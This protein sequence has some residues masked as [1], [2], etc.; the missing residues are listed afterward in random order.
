MAA[1][2]YVSFGGDTAALEAATAVVRG[3]MQHLGNEMR[4]LAREFNKAGA[5]A[6]SELGQKLRRLAQDM[7]GAKSVLA[8]LQ[9]QAKKGGDEIHALAEK[10]GN[11][12]WNFSPFS[13]MYV[14]MAQDVGEHLVKAFVSADAAG[15][16][17]G[18]TLGVVAT[19]GAL[20]AAVV[21]GQVSS[22]R[23]LDDAARAAKI[24]M[25]ALRDLNAAGLGVGID[26]GQMNREMAQF[27]QKLREAQI[28]GGDLAD[29]LKANNIA[30]Q[31]AAGHLRPVQ[32]IFGDI[33]NLI[34][35]SN[36]EMD[37]LAALDKLGFSHDMLRLFERQTEAVKTFASSAIAAQD[38]VMRRGMADG[39]ALS[40]AWHG[41]WEDVKGDALSAS[42]SVLST[43]GEIEHRGA[44]EFEELADRAKAAFHSITGDARAAA[45]A[46]AAAFDAQK[47]E[48]LRR[49]DMAV[50]FGKSP[51]GELNASAFPSA[52]K[53]A[54]PSDQPTIKGLYD[55][56]D[57]SSKSNHDATAAAMKASEGEI[58]AAQRT[59]KAKEQLYADGVRLS[60]LSDQQ[61]FAADKAALD[62]EY[63]AERG[64]LQKELAIDG[65]KLAQ[66]QAI[67]DK[68]KALDQRHAEESQRLFMQ[69]VQNEIQEWDRMIDSMSSSLSSGIAG[70][71]TYTTNFQTMMKRMVDQLL[72][73]FVKLGVD[74]VA[75][76]AKSTLA[77]VIL[78]QT[79]QGQMTAATI[80][81][82]A[83][84]T[85]ATAGESAA[86]ALS[87]IENALK[88]IA[89]DAGQA[90]AGV[91]AFLAPI[92]GPAAVGV[93]AATKG[94][95]MAMAVPMYDIGAYK[96]DQD[97]LAMVHRN[98]LV[99]PAAQAGA[100]RDMLDGAASG[101]GMGSGGGGGGDTTHNHFNVA[102]HAADA[103]SVRRLF[104]NNSK[105]LFRALKNGARA[106][107][108]L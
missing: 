36:N 84:R 95:V 25:S 2:I 108:H 103:E 44:V 65:L 40:A 81:G 6:E 78:S 16:A 19:A 12:V 23:D 24:S 89:I 70:M 69:T 76:W 87:L 26:A 45:A 49:E 80:A 34:A 97:Q 38:Q 28:A 58:Q 35:R 47:G 52:P 83:A 14:Q 15:A 60:I 86:G 32:Q 93:G 42:V 104:A 27:A 7:T 71:I 67:N 99:M 54:T 5:S 92:M 66:K 39:E 100:F 79:A 21:A 53:A 72:Q 91:A 20:S 101:R 55:K 85:S 57:D 75:N 8:G 37:K 3:K 105:E 64:L 62:E 88:T 107:H 59:F 106:G 10:L 51:F 90:G 22:L 46:T 30:I 13:G 9:E 94:A 102:I 68:L 61:K 1:D 74:L 31:D 4:S 82:A 29:F 96:I 43:L 73:Q 56:G 48:L 77:Q 18:V 11:A 50:K 63:N 33:A 98:E 17:L 41:M